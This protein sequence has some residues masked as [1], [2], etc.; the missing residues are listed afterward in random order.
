MFG[1]AGAFYVLSVFHY[2]IG[3]DSVPKINAYK[4]HFSRINVCA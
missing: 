2:V 4:N 3:Q 1:V